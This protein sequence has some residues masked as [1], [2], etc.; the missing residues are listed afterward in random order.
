M[1]I[2]EFLAFVR[3]RETIRIRKDAGEPAPWT[4][5][6][7]LAQYSF[8]N[9]RRNDDTVT[10]WLRENW[11]NPNAETDD[12][13]FASVVARNVN[14]PSTLKE[15]LYP[16]PW[17][18][19]MFLLKMAEKQARG[20]RL[21]RSA[22]M[23]R[24][25]KTS[26][27]SKAYGLVTQMFNPLW[28]RRDYYRPKWGDSLEEYHKTLMGAHG[29]GSFLAAQVVADIKPYGLLSDAP[30]WFTWSAPGPG[31]IQ[32]LNILHGRE[33]KARWEPRAF[34]EEVNAL[35]DVVNRKLKLDPPLDAQDIQNC[36][37]EAHK[38]WKARHFGI[39]P[40]RKYAR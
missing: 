17:D 10:K 13:W 4:N 33:L 25:G 9:I 29:L 27:L 39:A 36:L 11:F 8:C 16:D 22:Y 14:E 1:M 20:E 19:S 12:L 34:S 7:I 31:S 37:C 38:L 5:D 26:G 18:S 6:P 21:Y 40:R 35:Q 3:E 32:G 15:L 28:E 2:D 30:D 23:V 24:V